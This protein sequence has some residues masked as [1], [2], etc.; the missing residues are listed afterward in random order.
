MFSLWCCVDDDEFYRK[1]DEFCEWL[2]VP[3]RGSPILQLK[4]IWSRLSA[5]SGLTAPPASGEIDLAVRCPLGF[6]VDDE[7]V[8]EAARVLRLLHIQELTKIQRE[9]NRAIGMLQV[10]TA[11]TAQLE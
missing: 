9:I 2:Q 8:A 7:Q 4:C 5:S 6:H 1:L 10:Y 11:R 3:I